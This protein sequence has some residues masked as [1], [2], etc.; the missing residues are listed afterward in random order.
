VSKREGERVCL[1]EKD[2]ERKRGR[3]KDRERKR[4][5]EKDLGLKHVHRCFSNVKVLRV[6]SDG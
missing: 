5:R 1:R 6:C 2:R 3:E 4:G